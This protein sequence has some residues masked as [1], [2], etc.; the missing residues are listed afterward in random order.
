M[1]NL[2]LALNV[3][4]LV[5]VGLLYVLFFKEKKTGT[6]TNLSVGNDIPVTNMPTRIGYFNM[7]SVENGYTYIREVRE[8]LKTKEQGISAELNTLKKS[9]MERIQQLQSKAQTMS[10]TEG[11][12]AQGEINQMQQKL[13]AREAELTQSLQG[14]QFKMMQ[15]VNRKIEDFLKSYNQQKKFAF[16]LSHQPGDFIYYKDS[17]CNVTE[18][19]VNGLNAAAVSN[20]KK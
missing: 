13:Q 11:E 10:Q 4:L 14:E 9:Y 15:D 16:I 17:L 18:D 2:S 6:V 19:I 5:A 7:D 8:Q 1:K 12:T 3:I 20:K